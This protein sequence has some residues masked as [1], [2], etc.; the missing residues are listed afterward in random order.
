MA[1]PLSQVFSP[2]GVR[3]TVASQYAPQFKGLLTDLEGAG[4]RLNQAETGG[5]NPRMIR[6]T[7]IPS[8]HAT[9]EAVDVNWN[10]NPQGGPGGNLPP[11]LAHQLA[12]KYG[13]TWGGDW[14][15]KTRD[16]MHFEIRGH[17]EDPSQPAAVVGN[18]GTDAEVHLSQDKD[19][20]F[21][22]PPPGSSA[23]D[24]TQTYNAAPMVLGTTMNNMPMPDITQP[25]PA[26]QTTATQVAALPPPPTGPSLGSAIAQTAQGWQ[27][28]LAAPFRFATG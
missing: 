1:I 14:S 24:L 10:E 16:P 9:G 20:G 17:P 26:Q 3:V 11:E 13:L 23:P 15:G 28:Q 8:K 27:Q 4:Y 2:S 21:G 12:A 25:A 6:G 7:N 19:M 22:I 5:Y 18:P